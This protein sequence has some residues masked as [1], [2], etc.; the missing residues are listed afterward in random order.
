MKHGDVQKQ[1]TRGCC[2]SILL[3]VVQ[4]QEATKSSVFCVHL[5]LSSFEHVVIFSLIRYSKCNL[6]VV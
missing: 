3:S 4:E 5:I 1:A 2:H 6:S